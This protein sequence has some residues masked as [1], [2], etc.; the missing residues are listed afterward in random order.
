MDGFLLA[1]VSSEIFGLCEISDLLL[2]SVILFLRIK[3][4]CLAITFLMCVL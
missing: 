1:P 4:K 2:L 3:K